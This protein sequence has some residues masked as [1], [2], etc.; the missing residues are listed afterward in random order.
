MPSPSFDSIAKARLHE[1]R[2]GQNL[3]GC[4][5][6][7]GNRTYQ[8]DERFNQG[9]SSLIYTAHRIGG[10]TG[11]GGAEDERVA[12]KLI[13]TQ[14]VKDAAIT[15]RLLR[16]AVLTY[17]IRHPNVVHSLGVGIWRRRPFIIMELI[18][19]QTLRALLDAEHTLPASRALS[20]V[21][22]LVCG[23]HYL[24][25]I[26]RISAHRDIKPANIM[27]CED[28]TAKLIDFGTAKSQI[29][30]EHV[31]ETR[32]LGSAPYQAPEQLASPSLV[33]FKA[34][35]YALG[36]ILLEMLTGASPF[37]AIERE[38]RRR[39]LEAK[40]AFKIPDTGR[41]Q[42]LGRDQQLARIC[43][44]ILDKTLAFDPD[45]RFA[46]PVKLLGALRVAQRYAGGPPFGSTMRV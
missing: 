21:S 2:P 43:Q 9:A 1:S 25:F 7:I 26:G 45:D 6:S 4:R 24:Y 40:R 33:T 11:P 14:R 8:V 44:L 28:G 20:I 23:L 19:G 27:I 32:F 3:N 22:D 5:F 15:E 29:V 17:D 13:R 46:N 16:E 31:L 42:G 41:I 36:V 30:I 10:G 37:P 39:L 38:N 18:E 34:D 12:I 35:F